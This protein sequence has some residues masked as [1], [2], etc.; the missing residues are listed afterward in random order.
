MGGG[1]MSGPGANLPSA[2]TPE[3]VTQERTFR[4]AGK[5]GLQ[6]CGLRAN[7]VLMLLTS[8]GL[9]VW[10]LANVVAS[11]V[12]THLA[13]WTW[14]E[15][16]LRGQDVARSGDAMIWGLTALPVLATSILLNAIWF[17][18]VANER[19][20]SESPWPTSSIAIVTAIWAS[21]L[22]VD[23]LRGLGF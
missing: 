6:T 18:F 2:P 19:R 12:F 1:P 7:V 15:P 3:W 5:G 14:L 13:S 8:N 16:N 20:R 4:T 10:M 22:T 23:H 17:F 9:T 11:G 21:V